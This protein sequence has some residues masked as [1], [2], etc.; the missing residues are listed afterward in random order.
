MFLEGVYDSYG[1]FDQLEYASI[2]IITIVMTIWGINAAMLAGAVT[3]IT[4]YLVQ[5][6][7]Y[8]APVRGYMS[9]TTLRS[10]QYNRGHKQQ[11]ILNDPVA[12]R[13]RILVV[14]LQGH[15]FFGNFAHLTATISR[16]LSE[17]QDS[18]LEPLIVIMDFSLVLGIDSSAAQA[19]AK[20]KTTMQKR[21]HVELSIFV[22][23]SVDGFPCQFDL[24]KELSAPAIPST[25]YRTVDEE[26]V[27]TE[28]TGLLK[29]HRVTSHQAVAQLAFAGSHVCT[30]L[31][32]A[33]I[34]AENYL[35]HRQDA[36]LLDDMVEKRSQLTLRQ[37]SSMSEEKD[38]ARQYLK[39]ICPGKV[40]DRDVELLFS[41]FERQVFTKDEFLWKQGDPSNCVKLLVRGT[42]IATLDNE[43]GTR[44]TVVSGNMLGEVGLIEGA[45]RMSSVRC[46]SDEAVLYNLDRESFE[47]LVK[48]SPQAARLI[49]LICIRY[50]SARVQHVSNRI[51]ETRCLPI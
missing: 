42:L 43:A 3:A 48:S 35:I 40:S 39:D 8:V 10:S 34:F 51:F 31:D 30:T 14:Q 16:I 29:M 9:A 49:D 27:S 22:S 13:G 41:K 44:E 25:L 5:N 37:S 15:L 50:L 47:R 45:P 7:A 1:K 19:M 23:G 21:F 36:S 6:T 11:G 18:D 46:L 4:T 17:L 33:L 2:W 26:M 28:T 12:G 24:S 32:Q 20:L 38:M